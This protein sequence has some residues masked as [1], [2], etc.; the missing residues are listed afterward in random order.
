MDN[1]KTSHDVVVDQLRLMESKVHEVAD[2]VI[3][4]HRSGS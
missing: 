4:R 3:E 1:G 2:A